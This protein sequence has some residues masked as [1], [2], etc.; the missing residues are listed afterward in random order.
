MVFGIVGGIIIAVIAFLTLQLV[1]IKRNN[2][3]L[4]QSNNQKIYI[5]GTMH[6][7]HF[8]KIYH[9]SL[10]NIQSVIDMVNPDILLVETRQETIEK[11]NV[12]DGPIEMI[13]SWAYAKEKGINIQGVDWWQSTSET[14]ANTTNG[15]RDDHIF[16]N[17]I[18]ASKNRQIILV[19]CGLAHLP[20]QGKRLENNGYIKS[21]IPNIDSFFKKVSENDFIYPEMYCPR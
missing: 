15:V 12:I 1:N 4:Y 2:L 18:S 17:I 6:S 21:N 19:I 7:E 11:Y 13:F 9:Y 14:N 20:E 8:K 3:V 5:L 10:A 16:D